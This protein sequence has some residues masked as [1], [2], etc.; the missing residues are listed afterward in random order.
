MTNDG[1]PADYAEFVDKSFRNQFHEF[2]KVVPIRANTRGLAHALD[3][4]G[5][6]ATASREQVLAELCEQQRQLL[7]QY[8]VMFNSTAD[9]LETAARI[10]RDAAAAVGEIARPV[11]KG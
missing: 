2:P 7:V 8:G 5:E 6:R 1:N 4:A 11:G 10:L 9:N 3:Q